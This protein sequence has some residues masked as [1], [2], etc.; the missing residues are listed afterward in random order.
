LILVT[1]TLAGLIGSLADSLLGATIQAIYRCPSC[2]KETERYPVH[3]C[4][5]QTQLV[6]GYSWLDNDWVNTACALVGGVLGLL[7]I[8]V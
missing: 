2:N 8:M 6:R 1:I 3:T 7:A 5:S 4:G